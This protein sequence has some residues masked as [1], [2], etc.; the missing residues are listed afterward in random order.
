MPL[1]DGSKVRQEIVPVVVLTLA[2]RGVRMPGSRLEGFPSGQRDQTVNLTAPP[3]EVR[4]LP[5]PP[6][7]AGKAVK[8]IAWPDETSSLSSG[9]GG[10]PIRGSTIPLKAVSNVASNAMALRVDCWAPLVLPSLLAGY[11]FSGCGERIVAWLRGC[12]SMVELQPSKLNTW[13]R[14]PSP[15]PNDPSYIYSSG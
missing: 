14:F 7:E 1:F 5:P 6:G 4:I 11:G 15:A 2:R 10:E 8:K 9:G 12:S 3:S 13:V